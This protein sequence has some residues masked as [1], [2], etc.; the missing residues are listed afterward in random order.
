MKNLN[1]LDRNFLITMK[2]KEAEDEE[3]V[4]KERIKET[5]REGKGVGDKERN[6]EGKRE[7]E[8]GEGK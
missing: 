7:E 6:S 1:A 3:G 8:K 5:G 2:K 4:G